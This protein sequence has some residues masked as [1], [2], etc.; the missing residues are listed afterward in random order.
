RARSRSNVAVESR[1][2]ADDK[3]GEEPKSPP[4]RSRR[5]A[6]GTDWR[7]VR[8]GVV[9]MLSGGVGSVGHVLATVLVVHVVLVVGAG[10]PGHGV[11]RAVPIG[12]LCGPVWSGCSRAG[13]AGS[14]SCSPPCWCCT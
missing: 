7:A 11:G 4:R 10:D 13:C 9:R 5:R 3:A 14:G 2:T 6:R 12:G 1:V 8:A